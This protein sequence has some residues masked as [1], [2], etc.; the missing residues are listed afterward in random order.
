M[1]KMALAQF[2]QRVPPPPNPRETGTPK[3][4]EKIE[5]RLGVALPP[6]YKALINRYGSGS[7]DNFIT[8]YNPFAED[9]ERNPF[10]VLDVLHLA[11]RQTGFMGAS[12][13]TA[14]T[15]FNLYPAPEG[16]LPWGCTPA[17]GEF[18]FWQIKNAPHTWETVFYNLRRGEYEVW[19][20]TLTEFLYQLSTRKVESVL[21]PEGY[22]PQTFI[23]I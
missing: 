15:P 16:L 2:I 12:V 13:W 17:F 23:P 11:N 21:L 8:V 14:V 10:Y 19:K 3:T 9:E 18:F 7:F 1:A 5:A 20:Y 6:D 4:W 22:C